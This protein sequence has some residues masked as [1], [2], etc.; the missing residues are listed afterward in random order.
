MPRLSEI[1][2]KGKPN[3]NFTSAKLNWLKAIRFDRRVSD[4]DHRVMSGL[5]EHINQRT[6]LAY[7]SDDILAIEIGSRRRETV[8]RSRLKMRRLGYITWTRTRDANLYRINQ[9]K[10]AAT[11][12]MMK[13]LKQEHRRCVL[14][15]TSDVTVESHIPARLSIKDSESPREGISRERKLPLMRVIG[16]GR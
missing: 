2:P 4:F 13:R 3:P 8:A 14:A 6:G 11:L 1:R 12:E 9:E 16:G 15:R 7:V 5:A 10:V